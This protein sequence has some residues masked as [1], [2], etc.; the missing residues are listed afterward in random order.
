MWILGLAHSHNGAAALIHDGVVV[1]AVQ[2]ERI[3]RIKRY[4]LIFT[5]AEVETSV[6][7][8]IDYCVREAG[9]TAADVTAVAATTPWRLPTVVYWPYPEIRW[10][11]HHYAHAE[12][13]LHY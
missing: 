1:A 10:V 8:A 4:P 9:I 11:P 3:E 5:R 2:L 13:V 6:R 12:Y 7:R